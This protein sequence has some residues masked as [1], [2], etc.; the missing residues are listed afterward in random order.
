MGYQP[1]VIRS[2]FLRWSTRALRVAGTCSTLALT[3][4]ATGYPLTPHTGR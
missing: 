3:G 4:I 2:V 1:V